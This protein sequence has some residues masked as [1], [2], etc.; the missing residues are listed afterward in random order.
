MD[1]PHNRAYYRLVYP[2]VLRPRLRVGD[3]TYEVVDLSEEGVRFIHPGP[4]WPVLGTELIGVIQLPTGEVLAV[5][6]VVTRLAARSV[7]VQLS[8]GVTFAIMIEQQRFITQRNF[9][10]I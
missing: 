10:M 1:Y 5:E 3:Q 6:G 7:V 9:P 8:K 4:D 2:M